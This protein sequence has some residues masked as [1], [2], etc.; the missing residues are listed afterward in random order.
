MIKYGIQKGF[1]KNGWET[2]RIEVPEQTEDGL[3]KKINSFKPDYIFTEGGVDTK[4]FVFPVLEKYAI[5]HI[6][7][8]IEDPIANSTLA[9]EWSKRS[10]LSL[11]PDIEMLENYKKNGYRAICIPFGTDPDYYYHYPKDDHFAS[12][13]AIHIGNNYNCYPDRSRAYE[14][15]FGPFID[16]KKA[17]EVYGFDWHNPKHHFNL[18]PEY[19]K[20]YMAHETS[21]IAYSS[22]KIV[23]GVHSIT[24]SKTMQSMRTF[25]VLGCGGFFLTQHT[26]AIEAMFENHEHLIWS[27]C[28]DETVELM[29]F[30][31]G[32]PAVR[33]RISQCGQQFVYKN[34]SYEKRAAQIIQAL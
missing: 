16:Q 4:K 18:S 23:L 19:D 10:V 3:T 29:N 1:E 6:F 21:V 8:A 13:D 20:G 9:M 25:E 27:T 30:Y 7:W 2:D 32:H 12:L 34:H 33:E 24:N 26:P 22:A 31:L 5:P 28:Y 11:T 17:L 14:Y 15:I